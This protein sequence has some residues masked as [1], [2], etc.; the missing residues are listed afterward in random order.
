MAPCFPPLLAADGPRQKYQVELRARKDDA[1]SCEVDA[2][3]E[4]SGAGAL[5]VPL[6]PLRDRRTPVT[7]MMSQYSLI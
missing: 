1:E 6:V 4:S 2:G 3:S 5:T 7:G